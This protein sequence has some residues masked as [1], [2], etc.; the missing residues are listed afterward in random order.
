MKVKYVK[1]KKFQFV[2]FAVGD[3]A[4]KFPPQDRRK[5]EVSY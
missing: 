3:V 4:V 2:D 1:K 5:F